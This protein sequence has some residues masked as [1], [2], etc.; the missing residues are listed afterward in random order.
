MILEGLTSLQRNV[1][2]MIL[3]NALTT[4]LMLSSVNVALPSIATDLSMNAVQLSWIPMAYLMAGAMFVLIFGRLAD[5]FG[6][7][8]VFLI[9][10]S[11]AVI[12][13]IGA[14]LS[15][16]GEFLILFRF[17]QGISAAMLYATQAAIISSVFPPAKRGAAIGIMIS[18]LYF[19]LAAGPFVGGILIEQFGWQACFI[20]QIPL[21]LIVLYLGLIKIQ[22]DWD[23]HEVVHTIRDLDV[24]GATIYA[25]SI[26]ALAIGVSTLP[27]TS[28]YILFILGLTGFWVF[29][30][31]EKVVDH[32]VLDLSLFSD[33]RIFTLSC[34]ASFL[35]YTATFANVVLVSLYLQYLKGYPASTAGLVMMTQPLIMALFS[36]LAGRLS[37]RIEPRVLASYGIALT[38]IGLILLASMNSHSSTYIL[39]TALII[40]GAGFGLFSSPNTNAIMGAVEK[41]Q[42]GIAAG[43]NATMRVVGQMASMIMVTLIMTLMIGPV[44]IAPENYAQLQNVIRITFVLAA[45]ICLPGIYFSLSRGKMH[46]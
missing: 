42:Y 25:L 11:C 12:T 29:I 32:P 16:S 34:L 40:T 41:K 6:R 17:L 46:R 22:A 8:K 33:N 2:V 9:G 31:I 15:T 43:T 7:K 23:D 38:I 5:M 27:N 39:I 45:L 37:D 19:G 14:A 1:L 10:T 20:F 13:S 18:T 44:E 35:M 30:K 24:K 3:I 28:S 4:P 36:P 26:A 21:V